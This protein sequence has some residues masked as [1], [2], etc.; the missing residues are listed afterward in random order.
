MSSRYKTGFWVLSFG[1]WVYIILRAVYS[2]FVFDE[3][4]TFLLYVHNNKIIPGDAFWS[5]NNHVLNTALTW[6]SYKLL[7]PEEWQLRLPNLLAFP[8]FCYFLYNISLKLKNVSNRF[9]LVLGVFSGHI[10]LE[11]FGFSR[12]YGLSFAALAGAIYYGLNTLNEDSLKNRVAL[13]IC[14]FLMLFANLTLLP[15]SMALAALTLFYTIWNGRSKNQQVG[16]IVFFGAPLALAAF[17]SF[18][19]KAKGMLYYASENGFWRGSIKSLL[20]A[21]WYGDGYIQQSLFLFCLFG[22]IILLWLSYRRKELHRNIFFVVLLFATPFVFYPVTKLFLGVEY[23]LDRA[24]LY[25]PFLLFLALAF[26][27]ESSRLSNPIKAVVII[28]AVGPLFVSFVNNVSLKKATGFKWNTEQIPDSFFEE[29]SIN[30]A[31]VGGYF[32]RQKCWEYLN[33]KAKTKANV[34]QVSDYPGKSADYQVV[35]EYDIELF[36]Q[37]YEVGLADERSELLLLKRKNEFAKDA[38]IVKSERTELTNASGF[39]NLQELRI[40]TVNGP[41]R[42]DFIGDLKSKANPFNGLLAI[43]VLDKNGEQVLYEDIKL[44]NLYLNYFE[45]QHFAQSIYFPNNSNAHTLNVLFWNKDDQDFEITNFKTK[46]FSL[47]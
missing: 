28:A 25:L 16:N 38:L 46:V 45:L 37:E 41:L 40:D 17:L 36:E 10:F 7:G 21:F 8:V 3:A 6:I 24:L 5:A 12:G 15:I 30:S 13:Y 27:L 22:L 19:L 2:P 33:I 14:N 32:L 11:M 34:L 1:L 29:V 4:T 39:T 18:Q 47:K 20:Y 26:A 23:P 44:R 35:N 42:I 43:T 9:L 31:T